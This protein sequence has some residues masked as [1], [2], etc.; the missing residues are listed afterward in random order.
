MSVLRCIKP[1]QVIQGHQ[2]TRSPAE[3]PFF[4][5]L[6]PQGTI[7]HEVSRSPAGCPSVTA[8]ASSGHSR[9]PG[10][11]VTSRMSVLRSISLLRPFKVTRVSRSPADCPSFA[12]SASSEHSRSTGQQ[13]TSRHQYL[14]VSISS[15]HSRSTGQQVTSQNVCALLYSPSQGI[16][17]H[18]R[19]AGHQPECLCFAAFASSGHSRSP[20]RT[21]VLCCIRLLVA[22]NVTRSAGHQ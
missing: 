4:A 16:Q 20:A 3:C 9:S 18:T 21:S 22:F 11:Q 12:A 6:P 7:G 1:P 10:Q 14:I 8:S 5:D 2:V 13:V 19:S 17:G 15:G